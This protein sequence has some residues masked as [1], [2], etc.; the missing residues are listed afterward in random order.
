MGEKENKQTTTTIATTTKTTRK[1]INKQ[2]PARR[3][4]G[5]EG[6]INFIKHWTLLSKIRMNGIHWIYHVRIIS[7]ALADAVSLGSHCSE[8]RRMRGELKRVTVIVKTT[9]V[10]ILQ[11]Q[12]DLGFNPWSN[13]VWPW[14]SYL[15]SKHYSF[16]SVHLTI[17][18][19]SPRVVK[20]KWDIACN[21]LE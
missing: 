3:N 20:I 9:L 19:V 1:T 17:I 12:R 7:V 13:I 8:L 11:R 6:R 2:S 10:C 18:I 15:T 21:L 14:T 5:H 16:F 4:S